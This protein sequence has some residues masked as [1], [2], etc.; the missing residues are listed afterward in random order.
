MEVVHT[1]IEG[2][3]QIIPKVH[4]DSR[5]WFIELFKSSQFKNIKGGIEFTQDNL[6][7]SNKNVL[8]GLHL[9]LG[10]SAQAKLVV[11][12]SGKVLDVVVDLRQGSEPFG[13]SYQVELNSQI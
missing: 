5:G 4:N 1:D 11:V 10:S 2:L 13:K 12:L 7:F 8:R 9:Q 6:S 3:V